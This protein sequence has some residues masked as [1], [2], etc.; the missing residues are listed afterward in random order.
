MTNDGKL[1]VTNRLDGTVAMEVTSRL[2]HQPA[3]HNCR[4]VVRG[5]MQLAGGRRSIL[6]HVWKVVLAGG[7]KPVEHHPQE[8]GKG[9]LSRLVRPQ[10]RDDRVIEVLEKPVPIGPVVVN[11]ASR[12]SHDVSVLC[13]QAQGRLVIESAQQGAYV[14]LR[15]SISRKPCQ[16]LRNDD[17]ERLII[18]SGLFEQGKHL[19]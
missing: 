6:E 9:T 11:V 5:V 17:S 8:V 12:Y 2:A 16:M 15:G 19:G 13:E 4:S 1:A 3:L 10:N 7:M 18:G 14:D